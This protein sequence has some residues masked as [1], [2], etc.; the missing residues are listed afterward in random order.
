[1]TFCQ[2]PNGRFSPNLAVT[3]ES[4]SH[5]VTYRT[6]FS[7]RGRTDVAYRNVS[8]EI[9]PSMNHRLGNLPPPQK[10]NLKL[11]GC[12]TGT[13]LYNQPQAY[14]SV[15][16]PQREQFI[17]N[18]IGVNNIILFTPRCKPRRFRSGTQ[19]GASKFPRFLHFCLL[20]HA[21][22]LNVP[23]SSRPIAS[24]GF[25]CS[26]LRLIR[27]VAEGRKGC[28]SLGVFLRHLMGQLPKVACVAY[29]Q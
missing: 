28:L 23:F 20:F 10:K 25:H 19:Y 15:D 22:C 7:I 24:H 5:T 17:V 18:N 1:M 13:L 26:M 21:K 11:K 9:N 12:Q 14:S 8:N 27:V 6:E 29:T 3:R 2:L 4:I 16:A